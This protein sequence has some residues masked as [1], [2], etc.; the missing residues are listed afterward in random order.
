M[1]DD[2]PFDLGLFAKGAEPGRLRCRFGAPAKEEQQGL[3]G[4]GQ[5]NGRCRGHPTAA[6]GHYHHIPLMDEGGIG[7]GRGAEFGEIQSDASSGGKPHF[8]RSAAEQLAGQGAGHRGGA[9]EVAEVDGLEGHLGPL[10]GGCLGKA[11]QTSGEG[12]GENRAGTAAKSAV[13]A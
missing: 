8:Q 12:I 10:S 5:G 6:A 13:E 1:F 7:R 9:G 11:G 3:A 4:L 2:R